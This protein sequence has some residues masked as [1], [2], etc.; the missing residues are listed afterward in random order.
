MTDYAFFFSYAKEDIFKGFDVGGNA[1]IN[2]RQIGNFA[3]S[4]GFGFDISTQKELGRWKLAAIARDGTSTYNS[5]I[6]NMEQL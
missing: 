5:W 3:K 2:Y 4:W 1:K 6:C